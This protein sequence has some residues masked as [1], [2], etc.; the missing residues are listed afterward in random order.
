MQRPVRTAKGNHAMTHR[1]LALALPLIVFLAGLTAS[2]C[3]KEAPKESTESKSDKDEKSSDKKDKKEKD[4]EKDG[5]AKA[6]WI[7]EAGRGAKCEFVEW[8]GTGKDRKAYFKITPNS[9]KKKVTSVQTWEFYYD[10][11]G[12]YLDRY[13]HATSIED[14]PQDLGADGDGIA[15]GTDVVECEVTRMT[16]EDD[17]RWFNANLQPEEGDRPKGGV[18]KEYLKEHSGE[19]VEVEIVD[20]KKGKLK[21]HNI[22]DKEVKSVKV[23]LE[24]VK[25]EGGHDYSSDYASVKIKPGKTVEYTLKL[26]KPAP[27]DYKSV[28]ATAPRVTFEDDT[29]FSNKNLDAFE[30]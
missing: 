20:A 29:K 30:R 15:K 14:G 27:D 16:Y 9:T 3:N 18:T 13:P 28:V 1:P 11:D 10:K 21:L 12:K 24:F 23:E 7:D 8:K 4:K 19:K 22:S 25:K 5:P 6:A 2:G 26:E 17:T